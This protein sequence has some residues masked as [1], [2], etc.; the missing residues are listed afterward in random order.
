M[1]PT[2]PSL[3]DRVRIERA[4]WH[5][6][7]LVGDLP[8]RR[9]RA[10]RR[11]LRGNVHASAAQYG[12]GEALRRLG[13]PQQLADQYLDAEFDDRPRPRW[14]EALAWAV[15]TELLLA[16]LLMCGIQAFTTGLQ[17]GRPGPGTYVWAPLGAWGPR[18]EEMIGADG[19]EGFSLSFDNGTFVTL[20][21]SLSVAYFLGGR[22]WR[23]LP[24]WNR[25]SWPPPPRRAAGAPPR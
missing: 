16:A 13:D 11:E 20:L 21:V 25:R 3:A 10:I 9:R 15:A 4:L 7:T 1:P 14:K 5:L 23:S 22:M 19:F 18:Y 8:R 6:D 17:A 2:T 24:P 12:V